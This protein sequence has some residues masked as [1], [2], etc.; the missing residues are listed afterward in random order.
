MKDVLIFILF[1][2]AAA[3]GDEGNSFIVGGRDAAIGQFP[4]MVSIRIQ[5]PGTTMLA[6]VCGGGIINRNWVLTVSA[7]LLTYTRSSL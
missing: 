5:Q 1:L 2:I 3:S 6:H 7:D 4:Y